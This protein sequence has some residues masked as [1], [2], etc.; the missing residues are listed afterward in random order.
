MP[1]EE[2]TRLAP[3]RTLMLVNVAVEK[4]SGPFEVFSGLHSLAEVFDFFKPQLTLEVEDPEGELHTIVL[5]F[6]AL[7]DFEPDSLIGKIPF[8]KGLVPGNEVLEEV[9]Q[10]VQSKARGMEMAYRSLAAFFTQ[11]GGQP[12]KRLSLINAG[13]EVV[14]DEDRLDQL[15]QL[16][17]KEVKGK[18]NRFDLSEAYNFLVMPGYWGERVVEK[19]GQLA[20]D[21]GVFLLTDFQDATTSEALESFL[22]DSRIG[23]REPFWSRVLMFCNWISLEKGQEGA[24][25]FLPPS[26]AVAGLFYKACSREPALHKAKPQFKEVKG[27]RWELSQ[28][29]ISQYREAGLNPVAMMDKANFLLPFRSLHK[30]IKLSDPGPLFVLNYIQM[31]LKHFFNQLQ[32]MPVEDAAAVPPVIQSFLSD[33]VDEGIIGYGK[34]INLE[35]G[36]LGRHK[37]DIE[38]ALPGGHPERLVIHL[39]SQQAFA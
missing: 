27:A 20:S 8:L 33:L 32:F 34:V 11:A 10:E 4:Q 7:A 37:V 6:E 23:G 31:C 39:G 15:F 1:L 35:F 17:R 38:I 36:A 26:A 25:I 2:V 22:D 16:L 29:E 9:L 3:N 12:V 5:K 24:S 21:S 14:E 19:F 18:Y 30:G 28:G 13:P